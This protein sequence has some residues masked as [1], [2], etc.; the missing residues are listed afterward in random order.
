MNKKNLIIFLIV[1]LAAAAVAAAVIIAVSI[2]GKG[3]GPVDP[4]ET[5]EETA[6]SELPERFGD[7]SSVSLTIGND[8][9]TS[10]NITWQAI[11]TGLSGYV[12]YYEKSA[13]AGSAVKVE[14]VVEDEKFGVPVDGQYEFKNPQLEEI[15]GQ[16][17]RVYLTD[18]KP[19][20]EYVY[21]V[22]YEGGPACAERSFRTAS[23]STEFSFI[24]VADTQG[25]TKRN[26][27]V[28]EN[29]AG[30]A[31]EQCPDFDFVIHMG[32]AVEEGKNHYQWQLY[33]NAAEKLTA[34]KQVVD[35]A[36]NRDKR[37]TLLR[38][39][40]GAADNRAALVSGYYSFDWGNVHFAVL[41]T[42]DGD[43]DLPKSQLKWLSNDLSAAEGKTKIILMHKAPYTNT[44]HC[45]DSE[46]VQIRAQ[47]LPIAEQ[48]GVKAVI[49][50]HDHY[51][52]RSLPIDGE[53]NEVSYE[54]TSVS[55]GGTTADMFRSNGTVYF[56]NGSAGVKQH[57]DPI[58]NAFPAKTAKASLMKGPSFSYVTVDAGKIVVYTYVCEN[59]TLKLFDAFGIYLDAIQ[60]GS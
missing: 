19:D 52:F 27:D 40:N 42:N 50:G 11:E 14:S 23:E 58:T 45:M 54:K 13:D 6:E 24:L 36:G 28:W 10:A 43:K 59:N 51:F 1:V 15:P 7:F 2:A 17:H 31:A 16:V 4:A 30:L 12:S 29:L 25:F 38:Y 8:P 39:T 44:N 22:G 48:Y 41:N 53:G 46:I 26:F 57:D 9:R 21:T 55:I 60:S 3:P 34:G 32:D 33:F 35:V 18:L 47:I 49:C 37:H 56:V 20:T 5:P